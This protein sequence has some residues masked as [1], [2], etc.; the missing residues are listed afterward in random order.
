[1]K[2]ILSTLMMSSICVFGVVSC[3]KL[4]E[5]LYSDIPANTFY[6]NKNEV[7]SAVLRPYTHTNA[8]A[9]S[10]GQIGWWRISELS[11]D[12]LAWPRKGVDGQDGGKWARLHYHSWVS[13]DDNM[14]DPWRL[15][16]TGLGFCNSA[17][18][19]IGSRSASS[20]GITEQERTN[21]LSEMKMLHAFYYLR[22]MDLWGNVPWVTNA[23]QKNPATI[24]RSAIFDSVEN[25]IK[26]N[27]NG[28]A[29]MSSS[30][31][32]RLTKA[33]AFAMLAELY[34]N[35]EAW[36][37]KAR[38]QECIAACDSLIKNN[39]GGVVGGLQLD[40]TIMQTYMPNNRVTSQE[41]I[42]SIVYN[43]QT[44]NFPVGFNSDF[45]HFREQYIYGGTAN[46][47]NGIVLIPGVYSTFDNSDLRK[48]NWFFIGPM[49]NYN[50]LT[51]QD[52]ADY[53]KPVMGY[54]EY[55]GQQLVFVDAIK[56]FKTLPSNATSADSAALPSDM[57]KGEENSGVRFNKYRLGTSDNAYYRSTSWMIY[58]LSWI[59]YAKAEALMRQNGGKATQEAVDL[60]NTVRKRAFDPSV[61]SSK[62][63]TIANFTM[64]SLLAERGR[65]FIF[66]GYR[67][68][69]LVRFNKFTSGAW[70]D[71]KPTNDPN[72]L[73]FA[74]PSPQL[75]LNPNLVQN[76]GY[77]TN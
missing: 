11:A 41:Q 15:L 52:N 61:W 40:S 30:N 5:K 65:E 57:D 55:T 51:K 70:W 28:M 3:T 18:E 2:N 10:A 27:I 38:W 76:P 26:S 4:D 59:Y 67:R 75:A 74:V 63:F 71:H 50:T 36:T 48:K 33:G 45:Y 17:V 8:W 42:F 9:T 19:N 31:V 58:R 39:V 54:R 20:M 22:I 14:K 43:N 68:Q 56:Q 29:T 46:G 35:S 37:G 64:D 1:M 66:E 7:L 12:Q 73:L 69:D 6:S 77:P 53:T 34:L 47:N 60:I 23:L 16:W 13:N 24:S 49:W 25:E 32:G 44:A 72:K 21:Y 62:M